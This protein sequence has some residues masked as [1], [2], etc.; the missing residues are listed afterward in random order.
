M[1]KENRVAV[2]VAGLE[3]NYVNSF[4]VVDKPAHPL[5]MITW[6]PLQLL[7]I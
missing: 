7:E 6:T 5:E 2:H 1:E 3:G 4:S